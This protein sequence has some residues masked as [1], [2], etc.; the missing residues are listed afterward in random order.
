MRRWRA[1]AERR[2]A[3][4]ATPSQR[5]VND[6]R[7][8]QRVEQRT[9]AATA[10]A[11]RVTAAAV[12]LVAITLAAYLPA[13]W[14]AGFIWDD[15]DYVTANATLRSVDGLRRMW[16]EP[17]AVPQ[18]YP[19]TFTTFW[20]EYH[21][22]GLEPRGYH[23]VN[24]VLHALNA[25]L[26]WLI[27]RRLRVPGAWMAAAVFALHPMQVESVAWITERKNVLSGFFRLA[28]ALVYLY[29]LHPPT[30][31]AA[32]AENGNGILRPLRCLR[33]RYGQDGDV[34]IAGGAAAD[35]VVATRNDRSRHRMAAGSPVRCRAGDGLGDDLDGTAPRR[36]RGR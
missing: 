25:V 18:Y 3:P 33:A 21:L 30:M 12:L 8:E 16:L 36:G 1:P 26:L 13:V 15:D 23:V 27:L 35:R 20:A 7:R 11:R 9:A 31:G 19:L 24:V 29:G 4:L 28:A 10:D 32:N 22:W 34:L 2:N 6:R 17:D 14:N 5:Q